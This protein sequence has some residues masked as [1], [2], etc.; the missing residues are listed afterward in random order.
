MREENLPMKM[1]VTRWSRR[2]TA[3]L[4]VLFMVVSMIPM[5]ALATEADPP[6]TETTTP[7]SYTHL[8][9]PTT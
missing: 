1:T 9:L 4:L 5:T 7:V 3:L 2:L 6:T 8:T